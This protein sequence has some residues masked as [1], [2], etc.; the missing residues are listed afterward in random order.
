[1]L[2]FQRNNY[3]GDHKHMSANIVLSGDQPT[4]KYH[5]EEVDDDGKMVIEDIMDDSYDGE[6]SIK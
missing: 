2:S 1:M 3:V 6:K 5:E 4:I